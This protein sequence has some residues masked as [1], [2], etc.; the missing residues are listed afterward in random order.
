M[1]T[2][3]AVYYFRVAR[4]VVHAVQAE[5]LADTREE[6]DWYAAERALRCGSGQKELSVRRIGLRWRECR[7]AL[8]E[9]NRCGKLPAELSFMHRGASHQPH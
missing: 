9:R 8:T 5:H 6:T 7:G 3:R 2:Q 4:K 1:A